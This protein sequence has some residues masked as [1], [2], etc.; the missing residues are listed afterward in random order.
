MN[1]SRTSAV[2]QDSFGRLVFVDAEGGEH[3][4]VVPVRAHPISAPNEGLS[5]LDVDGHEVHWI[6]RL[7]AVPDASRAL[8][9]DA[10][11]AREFMPTIQ[12]IHAVSSFATPSTWQI[13]TDRGRTELVLKGEEDIRRLPGGALLIA[14]RHGVNY[15]LRDPAKL[16]RHS[17]KLLDRFL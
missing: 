1:A 8:L 2:H 16:D 10:L 6:D 12:R 3:V 4:G 15:L 11:R 17:R 9:E 13:D 14:D 7:D 5:L